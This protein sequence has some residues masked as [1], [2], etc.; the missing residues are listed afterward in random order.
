M[1][2]SYDMTF[3]ALVIGSGETPKAQTERRRC[4]AHLGDETGLRLAR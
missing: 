3:Y 4:D 1:F 2:L